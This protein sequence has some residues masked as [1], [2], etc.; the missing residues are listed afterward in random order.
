MVAD[1][2]IYDRDPIS[3]PTATWDQLRPRAVMV[4][5]LPVFGRT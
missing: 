1:L 4:S 3:E 2:Q 5:G